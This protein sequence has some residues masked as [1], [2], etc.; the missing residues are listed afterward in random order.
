MCRVLLPSLTGHSRVIGDCVSARRIE[1]IAP[2]GVGPTS[3]VQEADPDPPEDTLIPQLAPK[4]GAWAVVDLSTSLRATPRR[5]PSVS[6]S[7]REEAPFAPA[8]GRAHTSIVQRTALP[9]LLTPL[10]DPPQASEASCEH[11]RPPRDQQ[12]PASPIKV[13]SVGLV[14]STEGESNSGGEALHLGSFL[15]AFALL[16]KSSGKWELGYPAPRRSLT[17]KLRPP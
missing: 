2:L 7:V 4:C 15:S 16:G 10:R 11:R 3:P 9:G 5:E 14:A 8:P 17:S 6:G 1:A 13:L 12:E